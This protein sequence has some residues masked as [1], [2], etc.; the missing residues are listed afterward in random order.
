MN[1]CGIFRGQDTIHLYKEENMTFATTW[2]NLENIVLNETSQTLKYI[3]SVVCVKPRRRLQ[4]GNHQRLGYLEGSG[5]GEIL[6]KGR[7]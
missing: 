1:K 5:Y 2:M 4:S 6:F 7:T 3:R